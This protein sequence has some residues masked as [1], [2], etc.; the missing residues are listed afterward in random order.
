MIIYMYMNKTINNIIHQ[1]SIR[2]AAGTAT[3][4]LLP[5]I[6]TL[7]TNKPKV[8]GD[9]YW[10]HQLSPQID[11]ESPSHWP[12]KAATISRCKKAS[13]VHLSNL[14]LATGSKPA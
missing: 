9:F 1:K 8:D 2:N 10:E 12:L 4:Q 7:Q 14:A 6:T 11:T 3:G 5:N 13:F